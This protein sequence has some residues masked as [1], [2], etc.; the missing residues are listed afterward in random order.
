MENKTNKKKSSHYM[1]AKEARKISRENIKIT[2]KYE[3][4]KRRKNVPESEY[5][6]TMKDENNIVEFD[7][8]IFIFHRS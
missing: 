1:S 6:T 7:N 5:L 4:L 8:I 3:K 2:K